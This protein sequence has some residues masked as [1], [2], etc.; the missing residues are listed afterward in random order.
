VVIVKSDMTLQG[1]HRVTGVRC[2]MNRRVWNLCFAL[3]VRWLPGSKM[4][5]C[6]GFIS[7]CVWNRWQSSC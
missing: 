7:Y 2:C 3:R 6:L 5:K 1:H 4:K